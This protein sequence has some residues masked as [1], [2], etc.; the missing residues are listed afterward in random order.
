VEN[1]AA[2]LGRGID[3]VLGDLAALGYDAEWHCI[4]ASYVGAPHRRD[5]VWILAYPAP[6]RSTETGRYS[7]RQA[8]RVGF[9]CPVQTYA[10]SISPWAEKSGD[11]SG[12]TR[13]GW[14]GGPSQAGRRFGLSGTDDWY[15]EPDV[16]RVV[17]GFSDNVDR[18]AALGNAVVPQIPEL[19]GRAILASEATYR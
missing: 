17:D 10:A 11:G 18:D 7:E 3:V 19:I 8:E 12:E 15:S 4:P 6:Q 5:R 1:V 16:C 14:S 9:C 2:L 13:F